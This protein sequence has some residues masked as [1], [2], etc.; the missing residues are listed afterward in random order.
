MGYKIDDF[1]NWK[2]G[3]AG[4]EA[5]DFAMASQV[6]KLFD[7]DNIYRYTERN[8][9][10]TIQHVINQVKIFEDIVKENYEFKKTAKALIEKAQSEDVMV[11]LKNI[12]RE[13]FPSGEVYKEF[14]RVILKLQ[15]MNGGN[16]N[17]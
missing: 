3:S 15:E 17:D 4:K 9:K 14:M 7:G 8:K 2:R 5:F 16:N 1:A 10:L 11:N 6:F 12:S 13:M